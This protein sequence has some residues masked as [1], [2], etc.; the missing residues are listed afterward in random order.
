MT[1]ET[2]G[3][4]EGG[5]EPVPAEQPQAQPD[6]Q[7]PSPQAGEPQ[8]AQAPSEADS[9]RAELAELKD[10]VLRTHA[11]MDNMRKRL[12]KERTDAS[13]YAITRFARD[14]VTVGDNFQRALDTVPAGAADQTPVLKS[15][16]EGVQLTEREF[17]S[18]LERHGVK[19]IDP[20]GQPF[21]P[22]HHQAVM[23]QPNPDVPSGTVTQ[24]FQPGYM[25]EDRIL[26]PAMVVVARGGLKPKPPVDS[27]ANDDR[28]VSN[29]P[30]SNGPAASDTDSATPQT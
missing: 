27:A 21:N 28:P 29:G 17:L 10:R 22:H 16:L 7:S 2:K 13:K 15:F 20:K 11:E 8:A 5:S 18:V 1:H 4:G 12:E 25:I 19:R 6:A 9:L 3:P 26:R 30:V 24:V 23:E 14:I